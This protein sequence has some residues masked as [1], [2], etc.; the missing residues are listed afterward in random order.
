MRTRNHID[1]TAQLLPWSSLLR[2]CADPVV[3]AHTVVQFT[4]DLHQCY[5]AVHAL[6]TTKASDESSRVDKTL[7][8][9]FE[10]LVCSYTFRQAVPP[11]L[12]SDARAL[13]P[14]QSKL[15]L[16]LVSQQ[17]HLAHRTAQSRLFDSQKASTM[18][19]RAEI[20]AARTALH[21]LYK[22]LYKRTSHLCSTYAQ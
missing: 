16:H 2:M 18:C 21:I 6:K 1:L 14:S 13:Q 3:T 22:I 12:D 5:F 10:K 15:T 4:L 11:C 20:C 7:C 8:S 19:S 9:S 17:Q